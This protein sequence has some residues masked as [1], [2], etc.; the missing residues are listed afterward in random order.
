[1]RTLSIVVLAMFASVANAETKPEVKALER[2]NQYRAWAGLS[3]VRIDP[4]LSKGCMEHAQYMLKNRGTDAMVGLEAHTQRPDLPGAS[5]AGAKCGKAADLFPG[6]ANLELAIDGWMGGIY[7]RRPVLDPGLT[8]IGVG[9]AALPDGSLMAALMFG[10]SKD[11]QPKAVPYPA[12]N[13]KGVPLEYANEVPNPIPNQ[14]KGGYPITLQFPPFDKVTGVKATLSDAKDTKVPFHLSD[15]EHPATSFGQYGVVS[16]IP[17]RTLAPET[18]YT[19]SIDATWKGTKKTWTWSF[20]TLALR[21]IDAT[22]DAAMFAAVDVPSLV[23]GTVSYGGMMN[24]ETVF[25]KIGTSTAGHYEMLS[26]IVPIALWNEIA[27]KATPASFK[28][29]TVEVQASPQLV[30]GKY[31]NLTISEPAH[32]RVIEA[33]RPR[34][35]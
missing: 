25:L 1:M 32:F 3:A 31:M 27:G 14:G 18:R 13:M 17:K 22:D 33:A 20:T 34:K 4:V 12:P 23:R 28:G 16:V 30:K 6:V 7:H 5:V 2:V 19:V 15:P 8:T 24:T 9:Y 35:S 29:K 21:A 11:D 10:D 26:V